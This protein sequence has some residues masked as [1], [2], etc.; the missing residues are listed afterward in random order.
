M[1]T[2]VFFLI[3]GLILLLGVLVSVRLHAPDGFVKGRIRRV[4]RIRAVRT[5][6]GSS[7]PL[8]TVPGAVTTVPANTVV[9]EIIDEIEPV[10]AVEGEA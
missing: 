3:V 9:E 7:S 6:P 8:Q 5:V 10:E 2:F 1:G 4:W